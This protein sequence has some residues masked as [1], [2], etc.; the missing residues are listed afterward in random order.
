MKTEELRRIVEKARRIN[1]ELNQ[2]SGELRM[3]RIAL[4]DELAQAEQDRSDFDYRTGMPPEK[5]Q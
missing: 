2:L 3:V 5:R 4:E 1:M